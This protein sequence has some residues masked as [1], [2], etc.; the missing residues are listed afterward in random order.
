MTNKYSKIFCMNTMIKALNELQNNNDK[1]I[2]H[3]ANGIYVGTL[4]D[5]PD[6]DNLE[7]QE[8]DDL[9]TIYKKTYLKASDAYEHSEECSE[10]EKVEENPISITLENVT[11][12]TSNRPVNLPFVEIFIDQIIGVSVGSIDSTQK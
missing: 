12:L 1:L 6:Y 8:G 5:F 4:R 9:L 11:V 2:V 10:L 3:T 7:I